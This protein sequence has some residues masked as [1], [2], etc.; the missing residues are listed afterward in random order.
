MT[1]L[2]NPSGEALLDALER[3]EVR[4]AERAT[5]GTRRVNLWVKAGIQAV[6]RQS[7]IALWLRESAPD[8]PTAPFLDS[9]ALPNRRF[10]L[11]SGVRIVPGGSSVRRRAHLA[12]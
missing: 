1:K 7:G 2:E 5:H 10:A 11:E 3:G 8:G 6:F 9:A 4:A 12:S